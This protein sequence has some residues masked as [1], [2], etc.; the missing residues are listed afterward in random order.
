M[1][2]LSLTVTV[3][4]IA[5]A[6]GSVAQASSKIWSQ[7]EALNEAILIV[8]AIIQGEKDLKT[9]L[10]TKDFEGIDKRITVKFR[11]ILQKWNEQL[12]SLM[13]SPNATIDYDYGDCKHAAEDFQFYVLT[14]TKQD[15]IENRNRRD[16]LQSLYKKNL[17][18]CKQLIKAQ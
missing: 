2:K 17:T 1:K 11:Q 15:G 6:F 14:F 16:R 5:L 7:K 9:G 8:N 12:R 13:T 4:A 3:F 18:S 10:E